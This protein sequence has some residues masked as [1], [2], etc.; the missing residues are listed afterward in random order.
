MKGQ[1]IGPFLKVKNGELEPMP[2][3]Q[4]FLF[5]RMALG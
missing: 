3:Q 4:Q 2:Q 5:S 1:I